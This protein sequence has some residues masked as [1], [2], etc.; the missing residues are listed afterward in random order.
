MSFQ[1]LKFNL[2]KSEESKIK[3]SI[4]GESQKSKRT[5]RKYLL[6]FD[7]AKDF[8]CVN[9]NKMCKILQNMGL[10]EHVIYLP[11]NLCAFQ[12]A[13]VLEGHGT[14]DWFP[15]GKGACQG[16]ILSPSLLSLHVEI[17]IQNS[18]VGETGFE[19]KVAGRNVSNLR[20]QMT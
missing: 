15:V 13:T 11:R 12:E 5:S 7:Y 18:T 2:E 6:L 9:H 17:I 3:L 20:Y 10:L 16:S 8:V 19:I 14:T 4:P 1:M